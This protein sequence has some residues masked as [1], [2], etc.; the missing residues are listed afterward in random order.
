MGFDNAD[1]A[2]D[3]L[4]S[5]NADYA[6]HGRVAREIAASILMLSNCSTK[7]PKRPVSSPKKHAR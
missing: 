3:A 7:S 4:R 5:V 6:R 2:V 1:E